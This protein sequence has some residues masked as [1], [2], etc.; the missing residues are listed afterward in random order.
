MDSFWRFWNMLHTTQ[1]CD[2][3]Y[4]SFFNYLPN[5]TAMLCNAASFPCFFGYIRLSRISH[6]VFV[7]ALQLYKRDQIDTLAFPV[8]FIMDR[9]M[10]VC[11]AIIVLSGRVGPYITLCLKLLELLYKYNMYMNV[12]NVSLHISCCFVELLRFAWDCKWTSHLVTMMA[13]ERCHGDHR[14][15]LPSPK[16]VLLGICFVS[17]A[18]APILSDMLHEL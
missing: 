6:A 17:F 10:I 16:S 11:I 12:Y 18:N 1:L 8:R 14:R 7:S 5:D 2:I 15:K 3:V 4:L 13:R 9:W